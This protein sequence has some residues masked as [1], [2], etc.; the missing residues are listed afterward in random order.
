MSKHSQPVHYMYSKCWCGC[1]CNLYTQH[2]RQRGIQKPLWAMCVL[3]SSVLVHYLEIALPINK[4]HWDW[5][6]VSAYRDST[7][8]CFMNAF[9]QKAAD[10]N[11]RRDRY[12]QGENNP[13]QQYCNTCIV[14]CHSVEILDTNRSSKL[15]T[16]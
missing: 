2:T 3:T 6:I 7:P 9:T 1:K 15:Q 11:S 12:I 13:Y 10:N 16:W 14:C 5:I 4:L 8:V